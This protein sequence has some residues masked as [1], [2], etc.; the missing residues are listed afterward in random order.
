MMD[1]QSNRALRFMILSVLMIF[2]SKDWSLIVSL[3]G[4]IYGIVAYRKQKKGGI[5][6]ASIVV[7]G[8]IFIFDVAMLIVVLSN[9]PR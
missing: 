6:I 9:L 1:K 7:C 2:I 5:L 3:G 8:C 4:I